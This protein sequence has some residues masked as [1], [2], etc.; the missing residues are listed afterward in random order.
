MKVHGYQ[1]DQVTE[2]VYRGDILRA[3]GKNTSNIKNR[4]RK[5]VGIVAEIMDIL[6]C[7]SIGHKYFEMA[8][9]LREAR[10]INGILTNADVWYSL[11]KEEI[12]ELE[13]VDKMLLRRII[14]APDSTC[15]E[16]LYLELRV[17]PIQVVSKAR[18]VNYLHY[19]V[20]Q[21]KD[22]MLYNDAC[23]MC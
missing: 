18:R 1:A 11:K 23:F 5:L 12:D 20:N 9:A 6:N 4:V 19:L 14:A 16:S 8:K 22:N 13:D 21:D 17:I 10:L 7:V 3:D 2:A 15:I